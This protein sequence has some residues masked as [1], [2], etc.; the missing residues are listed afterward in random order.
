M[1]TLDDL[2]HL[3]ETEAEVLRA[4][5]HMTPSR[6]QV[7]LM[8]IAL[9]IRRSEVAVPVPVTAIAGRGHKPIT[10]PVLLASTLKELPRPVPFPAESTPAAHLTRPFPRDGSRSAHILNFVQTRG[11]ATMTE[12]RDALGGANLGDRNR[13]GSLTKYLQTRGDLVLD[14]EG[15]FSVASTDRGNGAASLPGKT[16]SRT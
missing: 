1:M 12:I 2:A 7:F 15:R 14:E 9:K 13:A 4:V 5:A 6:A 16:V 11:M 10:L 8:E 3:A